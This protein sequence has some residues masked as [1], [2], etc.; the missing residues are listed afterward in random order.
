MKVF[1][2]LLLTTILAACA[3]PASGPQFQALQAT[4]GASA[5]L[6]FYRTPNYSNRAARP[7]VYI[8]GVDK[9]LLQ[10]GGYQ[11]HTLEPGKKV[12]EIR[13]DALMWSV[14]PIVVETTM[15][16]NTRYF[17]R[18]KST[19]F[20]GGI[21]HEIHQLGEADALAELPNMKLSQ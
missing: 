2:S 20:V 5:V 10:D 4:D 18:L 11:V 19:P 6:Y 13:G 8:D 17:F 9:G 15:Q 16:A 3:S 14:K 21:S 1:L 7:H 12:L